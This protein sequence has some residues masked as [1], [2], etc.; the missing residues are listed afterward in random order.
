MSVSEQQGRHLGSTFKYLQNYFF[1]S[2]SCKHWKPCW[3]WTSTLRI[4]LR[5]TNHC[6]LSCFVCL[7]FLWENYLRSVYLRFAFPLQLSFT[8]Y[9]MLWPFKRVEVHNRRKNGTKGFRKPSQ[10]M[11]L[12]STCNQQRH[13]GQ[14]SNQNSVDS[15]L[16]GLKF[17]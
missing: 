3:F 16:K 9:E 15:H 7:W 14:R 4:D 8:P 17:N 12:R 11:I 5:T 10:S 1:S 13:E 6:L 2:L